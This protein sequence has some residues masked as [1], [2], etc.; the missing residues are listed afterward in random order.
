MAPL[1]YGREFR[2][3][4]LARQAFGPHLLAGASDI[5]QYP[6]IRFDPQSA[7]RL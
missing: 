1:R 5:V 4:E 3:L 7:R 2:L 6:D